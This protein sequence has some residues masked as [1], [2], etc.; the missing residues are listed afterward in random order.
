MVESGGLRGGGDA[1]ETWRSQIDFG[2]DVG[3]G[4][5]GADTEV[6]DEDDG[7]SGG[8]RE[9]ADGGISGESGT[10]AAQEESNGGK[11][12]VAGEDVG[13]G[14]GTGG[15]GAEFGGILPRAEV[16]DDAV[17]LTADMED[18]L[19]KLLRRPDA[20]GL[21]TGD[22]AGEEG[23][24]VPIETE[25]L[26]LA[27]KRFFIRGGGIDERAEGWNPLRRRAGELEDEIAEI[28]G[29]RLRDADRDG[30][31]DEA[32]EAFVDVADAVGDA[33]S[34]GEEKIAPGVG[35]VGEGDIEAA[36]A[37]RDEAAAFRE[38]ED[39]VARGV[40][41]QDGRAGGGGGAGPAALG[42]ARAEG[43]KRGRIIEHVA[44]VAGAED[45]A[46]AP[47]GWRGGSGAA[48]EDER[49]AAQERAEIF[50]KERESEIGRALEVFAARPGI[51][52]RGGQADHDAGA[53][54]EACHGR[55]RAG[56]GICRG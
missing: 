29:E 46:A 38:D 42:Q 47:R 49:G 37:E 36:A 14:P 15:E 53:A 19:K 54:G 52:E 34:G 40:A 18:S 39:L 5:N 55:R 51:G 27:F 13:V 3:A 4:F 20:G 41:A 16:E 23:R 2:V 9:M 12:E 24:S 30:V 8:I 48:G 50:G 6:A 11:F 45:E 44:D 22:G 43:G 35:G 33:E 32:G 56:S 17:F 31:R 28:G 7:D 26:A 21:A 1:L 10:A 25:A